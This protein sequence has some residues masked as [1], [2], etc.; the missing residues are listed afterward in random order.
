MV[1]QN[2]GGVWV[3]SCCEVLMQGNKS[4]YAM[5]CHNTPMLVVRAE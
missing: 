4:V 2:T 3:E 5:L 1:M